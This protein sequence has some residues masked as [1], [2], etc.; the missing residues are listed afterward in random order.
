MVKGSNSNAN[1]GDEVN[2]NNVDTS[3]M[4]DG[5]FV[6]VQNGM[7]GWIKNNEQRSNET[8]KTETRLNPNTNKYIW[9]IK[10]DPTNIAMD[11]DFA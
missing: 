8:E 6:Q 2:H 4:F 9:F 10:E 11:G 3:K 7:F 5:R 1:A